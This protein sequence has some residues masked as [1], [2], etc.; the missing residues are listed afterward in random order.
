VEADTQE[1]AAINAVYGSVAGRTS[2]A[3]LLVGSINS[4]IGHCGACS[5]LA[6]GRLDYSSRLGPF[7]VSCIAAEDLLR[8]MQQKRHM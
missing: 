8:R 5:G 2:D 1:L 3:P 7:K 6:G 4:N